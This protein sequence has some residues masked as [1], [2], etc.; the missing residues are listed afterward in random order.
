[1]KLKLIKI[2][3]LSGHKTQIYSVVVD[4]DDKSL[5]EHFLDEND[6]VYHQELLEILARIKSISQK[7]GAREHLLKK[8]KVNLAM[9]WKPFMM[10]PSVN[11]DFIAF[12]MV[13]FC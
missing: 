12:V 10:N 4:N 13:R 2:D 5:F 6:E 9:A 11:Y 1:V 3:K 7:E 8:P